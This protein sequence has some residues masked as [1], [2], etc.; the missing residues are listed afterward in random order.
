[1]S[2]AFAPPAG[3]DYSQPAPWHQPFEGIHPKAA[4][5]ELRALIEH[6]ILNQPRSRQKTIG[7]SEIGTDCDHCLAAKLAGWESTEQGVPWL[8]FVGTAVHAALEEMVIQY[9]AN[10]NAPNTTG[11]RY[12]TEAR[13]MVGVIDGTEIWGSTD[14][15]DLAAGVT[16]DYKIVGATTLRT[17]KAGPSNVYRVQQHLYAKGWNDAGHRIDHVAIAYLPRN[18][19]VL[20]DAVWWN[21]PY[22]RS[23]AQNALDRANGFAVNVRALRSISEA[24]ADEY[25]RALPRAKSCRD[26]TRFPDAPPPQP[27]ETDI[28]A[29]IP[30]K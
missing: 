9:E 6:S 18:S 14:L 26:C 8:P 12:L 27:R 2:L 23:I 16:F 28:F 25:I 22:D 7:P 3:F 13:T 5:Q 4:G 24:A 21:E 11:R 19:V 1:M 30:T 15:V 20:S 17:A 10:R 29:G